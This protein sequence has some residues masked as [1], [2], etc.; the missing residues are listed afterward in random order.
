MIRITG[1]DPSGQP[2]DIHGDFVSDEEFLAAIIR[3]DQW[4]TPPLA[5]QYGPLVAYSRRPSEE[6]LSAASIFAS[7]ALRLRCAALQTHGGM[8]LWNRVWKS[9][10]RVEIDPQSLYEARREW[11]I[12]QRGEDDEDEFL[13]D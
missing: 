13:R 12:T 6:Q 2:I 3:G 5:G 10:G 9:V 7:R 11:A 4:G 1:A 8:H